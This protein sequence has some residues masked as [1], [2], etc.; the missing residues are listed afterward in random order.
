LPP[1]PAKVDLRDV[2]L[3]YFS[4]EGETEALRRVSLTVGAGEFVGIVGQSGCG[5]S[6][7]LSLIAGILTPTAGEILIDGRRVEGTSPTCGYM[8]QQDYLFE[9]RTILENALIG[10]EIQGLP[11]DAARVRAERLL[12]RYGLGDFLHHYPRQLSGGMRQRVALARTLCTEPEILL[13]D[14]PFSALDFQTRLALADEMSDIL[15]R[16]EKTAILV[17]HDISEAVSMCDRVLVMSRRPGQ[18]RTEH[19]I[20]FP[21]RTARPSPFEARNAPEFSG[22]FN[23]IWKELDVH[24]EG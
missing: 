19:I 7:L 18:I 9:W 6:T 4:A 21:S 13:L 11:M 2:D 23:D 16:E 12:R 14:E 24:V 15:R 3:H 10:P 17:T 20:S 1:D 5:K 22:Y 8:L